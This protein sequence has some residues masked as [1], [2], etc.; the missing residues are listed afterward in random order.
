M[1][2]ATLYEKL[3]E[4]KDPRLQSFSLNY[5]QVKE[6]TDDQ[7]NGLVSQGISEIDQKVVLYKQRLREIIKPYESQ[8]FTSNAIHGQYSFSSLILPITKQAEELAEKYRK[9]KNRTRVDTKKEIF[10]INNKIL[11]RKLRDIIDIEGEY[12]VNFKFIYPEKPNSRWQRLNAWM[13]KHELG[14]YLLPSAM[15]GIPLGPIALLG[16]FLINGKLGEN[17]PPLYFGAMF[18]QFSINAAFLFEHI[19]FMYGTVEK[20]ITMPTERV[21]LKAKELDRLIFEAY[22]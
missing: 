6:K 12:H 14:A 11:V 17:S 21:K 8:I 18:L 20:M 19:G 5:F 7:V 15:L 4:L 10:T 2:K 16:D 13:E 22:Y 3:K 1:K 9:I